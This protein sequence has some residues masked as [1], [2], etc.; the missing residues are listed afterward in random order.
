MGWIMGEIVAMD[1]YNLC[2]IRLCSQY[3]LCVRSCVRVYIYIYI[4]TSRS[5]QGRILQYINIDVVSNQCSVL[6]RSVVKTIL[7]KVS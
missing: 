1:E 6:P 7:S 3:C 4:C 5:R 2:C